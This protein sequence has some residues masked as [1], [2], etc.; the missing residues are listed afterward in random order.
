MATPKQIPKQT[1]PIPLT[2]GYRYKRNDQAEIT[3]RKARCSARGDEMILHIHFD[4][5]KTTT[6]I[7]DKTTV[8][9]LFALAASFNVHTANT[10][11]SKQPISMKHSAT[12]DANQYTYANTRVSTGHSNI[13]TMWESSTK[14]IYGTPGAGHKHLSAIFKL[15]QQHKFIQSEADMCLFHR[16]TT[17]HIIII[18][19][20]MEDFTVTSTLKQ[21]QKTFATILTTA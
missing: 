8:R 5:E 15:L 1:K 12:Q 20:C 11:T 16:R 13:N 2:M 17:K 3:E 7:A 14:D 21:L 10:Y 4:P 19:V 18:S 6:Y 9:I